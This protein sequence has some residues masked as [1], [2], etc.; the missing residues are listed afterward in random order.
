MPVCYNHASMMICKKIISTITA[1]A[2]AVALFTVSVPVAW[3]FRYA[4]R[5]A[6][7]SS[8]LVPED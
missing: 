6:I 8:S 4:S 5:K 7:T 2:A 3:P 1:A